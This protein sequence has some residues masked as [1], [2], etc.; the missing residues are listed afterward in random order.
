MESPSPFSALIHLAFFGVFMTLIFQLK[1]V[2]EALSLLIYAL[3]FQSFPVESAILI[4]DANIIL[5]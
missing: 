5:Q 3:L 2:K 1:Q 4:E